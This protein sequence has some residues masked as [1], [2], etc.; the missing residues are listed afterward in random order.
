[1][2][3]GWWGGCSPAPLTQLSLPTADLCCLPGRLQGQ[4]R[5]GCA[6]VP[7]RLSPQVSVRRGTVCPGALEPNKQGASSRGQLPR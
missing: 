7:T 5:A 1:M 3:Q 4:G 6:P 2:I